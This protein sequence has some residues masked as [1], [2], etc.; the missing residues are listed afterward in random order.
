M[1][2]AKRP[3]ARYA[4]RH[5]RQDD[6]QQHLTG[7]ARRPS[8]IAGRDAVIADKGFGDDSVALCDGWAV[9]AKS[10]NSSERPISEMKASSI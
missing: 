8:Q 7:A 9:R 2:F 3:V 4:E 6:R 5:K 1:V 10:G